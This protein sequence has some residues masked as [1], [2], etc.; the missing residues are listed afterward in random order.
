[1]ARIEV[2]TIA[3]NID[4]MSDSLKESLNLD[5]PVDKRSAWYILMYPIAFL[6]RVK[7]ERQQIQADKMNVFKCS[8][9][10]LDD[11]LAGNF[12]F[13]RKNPSY[14]TVNI[15]LI[16]GSGVVLEVSDIVLETKDGIL[17]YLNEAG[18]LNTEGYFE[19]ICEVSGT[20]GNKDI[21]DIVKIVKIKNGVYD[22][23]QDEASAGG[24]DEET[25]N[26][27]INRWQLSKIDSYWNIDGIYSEILMVD[28][29]ESVNV[30]QNY[31]MEEVDGMKPKSLSVVVQGGKDEDIAAAIF[32]KNDYVTETLG[33]VEVIVT[34]LQGEDRIIKFSRPKTT[35]VN[36]KISYI[37]VPGVKITI[38]E[39]ENLVLEYFKSLKIGSYITS[40]DCQKQYIRTIYG[41]DK[42]L[43]IDITFKRVSESTYNNVLKLNFNEVVENGIL[44]T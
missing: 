43:N 10:D 17:F 40:D 31:E 5:I 14:A 28:G 18:I 13:R 29:V 34:D 7:E 35:D 12:D 42:L 1:M 36:F 25:D 20:I 27:Y 38:G 4:M 3:E 30:N 16:G 21:G 2:N 41:T 9:F 44:E 8:G 11:I 24:Q 6:A 32:K 26:A 23:V 39:L 15:K 37:T 22:F 19:F 33:D